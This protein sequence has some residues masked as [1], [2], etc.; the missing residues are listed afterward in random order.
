LAAA[1]NSAPVMA[2][3]DSPHHVLFG[4][5]ISYVDTSG[6]SSWTEGSV[7]KLRF[8]DSNDGLVLSRAFVD[9]EGRL[10]DTLNAKVALEIYDDDLGS[11]IDFTEAYLEWRPVPRS[12]NRYRLKM[13]A[14]YPRISLENT[15]AGWTSPYTLSSSTINTWVAEELRTF[16]AEFSITR[17]PQSLGGAHQFGLQLAAFRGNDP[18]GSLLAWKGWSAHDRQSRFGDELPLPPLPQIQPGML[19]E[20]QDPYVAPFREVDDRTGFYINGEWQLGTRMLVRVMHYD[21]RADPVAF[22]NG[23]YAWDTKFDHIGAQFTLPGDFALIAQWM[24]G[25]TVMGPVVD[26]AHMVDTEFDSKFVM[27]TRTFGKHRL[28]LRYDNF[29]ITQNDDTDE[30]NNPEDGLVW[31]AAYQHDYSDRMSFA[32]EWL[33]IKTH[34]CGWVYYGLNPTATEK[35]LQLS[36]RFKFSK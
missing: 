10:S 28:S 19:F 13:G 20:A 12:P 11:P 27:L 9:Y 16:G 4:A 7:G 26:D 15:D 29:D 32:A 34:H 21:N 6:Y 1:V 17:R 22:E 31:T 23:Q 30:D 8:D 5:D 3:T 35:Q 18:T 36:V 24:T 2:Q 25:S 14:F 33:S